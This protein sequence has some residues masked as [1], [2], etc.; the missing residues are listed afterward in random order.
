MKT[1]HKLALASLVSFSLSS[2]AMAAA[3]QQ[4][5]ATLLQVSGKAFIENVDGQ[6]QLAQKGMKIEEGAHIV[7]LEKSK[8]TMGYLSSD[9]RVVHQQNTLL[10]VQAAEQ[11]SAGQPIAVGAAGAAAVPP[12]TIAAGKSAAIPPI[13]KGMGAGAGS[14]GLGAGAAGVAGLGAATIPVLGLGGLALL[15]GINELNDDDDDPASR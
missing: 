3:A 1:I 15:A 8:I 2:T 13:M 6:R 14:L 10:T 5:V 12:T 9:C 4:P 7:V 11:C